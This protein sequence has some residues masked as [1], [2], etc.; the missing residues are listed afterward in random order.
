M[1]YI[2]MPWKT[3][4]SCTSNGHKFGR[5]VL[6]SEMLQQLDL[7]QGPLGQDLLAED[8]RHLLNGHSLARLDIRSGTGWI[9]HVISGDILEQMDQ[10]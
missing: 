3:L 10:Y 4:V 6:T 9:V 8:I 1:A 7:A 2:T 5:N